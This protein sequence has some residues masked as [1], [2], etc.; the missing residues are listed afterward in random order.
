MKLFIME[1]TRADGPQYTQRTLPSP[2]VNDVTLF[3][4]RNAAG[5][6]LAEMIYHLASATNSYTAKR[7]S[8]SL[9]T[10]GTI[11]DSDT[12]ITLLPHLAT[13]EIWNGIKGNDIGVAMKLFADEID[14]LI[15][16]DS[17]D[18]TPIEDFKELFTN[19][20]DVVMAYYNDAGE[21]Q[22]PARVRYPLKPLEPNWNAEDREGILAMIR[23]II[24][25]VKYDGYVPDRIRNLWLDKYIDNHVNARNLLY[26]HT[27]YAHIG[28]N[29][30]NLQKR[31][32]D[33]EKGQKLRTVVEQMGVKK[34]DR[35]REGLSLP[36]LAICFMP[37]YLIYRKFIAGDL[38]SQ[39][40]SNLSPVYKDI[41]FHGCP[42]IRDMAGY[43]EFHKE[44]ST[45]IY[46]E[47]K[48]V[49][50]EDPKFL[51]QYNQWTRVSIQGYTG[52]RKIHDR[53]KYVIGL[54]ELTMEQA[55][56][57]IIEGLT[58]YRENRNSA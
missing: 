17:V 53:M 19:G 9:L 26:A 37:E 57:A 46:K 3:L 41:C 35:T 39:T 21:F 12:A 56:E 27:A 44:F 22:A 10:A 23:I 30:G 32:V 7:A 58:Y 54:T 29:I 4:Q 43:K 24:P 20:G 45:Y 6:E 31:R 42:L 16:D 33:I 2:E 55:Y 40:E 48:N 8:R 15:D 5:N 51:K 1:L 14:V 25:A 50:P 34:V 52:D 18:M 36:R 11:L 47:E 49:N 38:Q 28:N 13:A